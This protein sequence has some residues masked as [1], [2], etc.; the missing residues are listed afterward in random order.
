MRYVLLLFLIWR[1]QKEHFGTELPSTEVGITVKVMTRTWEE[2]AGPAVKQWR[3]LGLIALLRYR[4]N[5]GCTSIH[6]FVGTFAVSA[7]QMMC[8]IMKN[9]E[10]RPLIIGSQMKHRPR[11]KNL[12]GMGHINQF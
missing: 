12:A 10:F 11:K 8:P 1:Q 3:P 4:M 2:Q 9:E 5:G 7:A 6:C